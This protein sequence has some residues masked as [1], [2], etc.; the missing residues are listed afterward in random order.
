[1]ISDC[2][3]TALPEDIC[4]IWMLT[5]CSLYFAFWTDTSCISAKGL[6]T[7]R[8]GIWRMLMIICTEEQPGIF[9][10]ISEMIFIRIFYSF[11][12]ESIVAH[13]KMFLAELIK[14]SQ[15]K[16]VIKRYQKSSKN[17][18]KTGK[19]RLFF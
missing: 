7:V 5:F 8:Y 2:S 13:A 12:H 3:S 11:Y 18:K 10:M 4:G 6:C 17:I 1:M 16:T 15:I 19:N 9:P 14:F